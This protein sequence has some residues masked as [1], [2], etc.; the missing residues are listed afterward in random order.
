MSNDGNA[1]SMD[2]GQLLGTSFRITDHGI[3]LR[4]ARLEMELSS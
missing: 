2:S 1:N 4:L 3:R